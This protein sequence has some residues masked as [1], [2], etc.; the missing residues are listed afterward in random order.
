MNLIEDDQVIEKLS[1]TASDPAFRDSI[2][3][4]ACRAY[5]PG[6]QAA[7]CQQLGYRLAK[8]A[9]SIKNRIAVPTRFRKCFLQ[10]L[11]YPRAGRVFRDIEMED[12][13]SNLFDDEQTVQDSEG[14][15]RHGEEVHGR[16]DLA[17]IAKE[18]RPALAG[19][20]RR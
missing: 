14:E 9:V 2:L 19:V 15:R 8:L 13:A 11:H 4:W 12:L 6:F 1:A 5:A 17:V 16:D 10:L 7:G 18:S 20:V 3:P